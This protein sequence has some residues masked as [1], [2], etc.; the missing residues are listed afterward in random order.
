[1]D[2][3]YLTYFRCRLQTMYNLNYAPTN[4]GVQSWR[5]IKCDG[6][7]TKKFEYHWSRGLILC[8]NLPSMNFQYHK[9]IINNFQCIITKHIIQNAWS[10][11]HQCSVNTIIVLVFFYIKVIVTQFSTFQMSFQISTMLELFHDVHCVV[12]PCHFYSA[13]LELR[14]QNILQ[15]SAFQTAVR[16]QPP[17]GMRIQELF[18]N[19]WILEMLTALFKLF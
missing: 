1:L 6:T 13:E 9:I 14:R 10:S 12:P 17:S 11:P 8:R 18:F 5:E 3:I 19:N 16:G 2:V 7:R 4:L 15:C